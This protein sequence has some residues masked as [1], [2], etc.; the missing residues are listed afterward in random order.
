MD[1]NESVPAPLNYL[2]VNLRVAKIATPIVTL[3]IEAG[4]TISPPDRAA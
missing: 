4:L 2:L 3:E 1:V